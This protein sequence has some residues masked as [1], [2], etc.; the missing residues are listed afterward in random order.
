M[1]EIEAK[2]LDIDKDK[3]E[4]Q[5]FYPLE[6]K[7]LLKASLRLLILISRIKD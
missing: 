4:K 1:R 5:L 7:R 2:I 6:Q 3:V